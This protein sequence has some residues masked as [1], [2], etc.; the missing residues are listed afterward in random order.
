MSES[1]FT[2]GPWEEE[3]CDGEY[4]VR[5]PGRVVAQDIL[6]ED[7]AR[8]IAAAPELL[9]A[10]EAGDSHFGWLM[11]RGALT[12]EEEPVLAQIRAAIAKARGG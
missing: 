1:K 6:S 3:P 10:C 9:A 12:R 5:A 8:L 7:D 4:Y 11:D 2:A